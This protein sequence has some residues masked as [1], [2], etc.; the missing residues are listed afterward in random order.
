MLASAA[1][2]STGGRRGDGQWPGEIHTNYCSNV[3]TNYHNYTTTAQLTFFGAPR[4]S[5]L[6]SPPTAKE[7]GLAAPPVTS[8]LTGSTGSTGTGTSKRVRR[9]SSFYDLS[10]GERLRL[11]ANH[12]KDFQLKTRGIGGGGGGDGKAGGEVVSW[13]LNMPPPT[14]HT[15]SPPLYLTTSLPLHH[16]SATTARCC[17]M[18]V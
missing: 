8:V 11:V 10:H 4:D 18:V 5:S 3:P 12:L 13:M 14:G 15:T 2:Q 16:P 1:R 17:L 7:L 6:G 9:R